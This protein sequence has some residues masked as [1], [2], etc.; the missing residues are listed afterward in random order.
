MEIKHLGTKYLILLLLCLFST[1]LHAED[2]KAKPVECSAKTAEKNI[3]MMSNKIWHLIQAK[4][5]TI[6]IIDTDKCFIPNQQ[7]EIFETK[8]GLGF[9]YWRTNRGT[10]KVQKV[11]KVTLADYKKREARQTPI[12]EMNSFTQ[13]VAN[14]SGR[15]GA[16]LETAPLLA[17]TVTSDR[18]VDSLKTYGSPRIHPAGK[19]LKKKEFVE[20]IKNGHVYD[21]RPTAI[22][23][24][25]PLKYAKSL[26]YF[27]YSNIATKILSPERL[28]KMRK[29]LNT[30][31]LPKKKT[32]PV[33]II[34]GCPGEY[35][36]YNTLTLLT[37]LGYE[38]VGW[39]AGGM[40][41]YGK[42]HHSCMTPERS[43]VATVV[44]ADKA[45]E[46]ATDKKNIVVDVRHQRRF[47]LPG[48]HM[49]PFP[50]K[51]NALSMAVYRGNI[52]AE[53]LISHKE[54]YRRNIKFP[55][56]KTLLIVGDNEYDW[57]AYKATF[58]FQSKGYRSIY[59]YRKGMKD[60]AQKVLFRPDQ[61]K[62]NRKVKN[63]EL[64]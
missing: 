52:D 26:E 64:Y 39:F 13:K 36:G 1:Q 60:W 11:E 12:K 37:A 18:L 34:A 63:G 24:K 58:Y 48:S 44:E 2:K 38:N 29:N 46:I 41:E 51:R 42:Q 31:S 30:K 56:D 3:H 5:E 40:S 49:M 14:F 19:S 17:V 47:F 57:R 25:V 22:R 28:I 61:Y 9:V 53:G 33:Y 43:A 10:G 20:E 45:R 8:S 4:S 50:E 21:I 62:L 32:E 55:K 16:E 27:D 7:L 23:N 54:G 35:S 6:Y 15:K 59:W